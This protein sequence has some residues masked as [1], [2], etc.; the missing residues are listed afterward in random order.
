MTSCVPQGAEH[1]YRVHLLA[2]YLQGPCLHDPQ[3]HRTSTIYEIVTDTSGVARRE[4]RLQHRSEYFFS[5][6]GSWQSA[7]YLSFFSPSFPFHGNINA[8]RHVDLFKWQPSV[9]CGSIMMAAGLLS[10][11]K[12]HKMAISGGEQGCLCPAHRTAVLLRNHSK[13]VGKQSPPTL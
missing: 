11:Y 10:S 3:G 8:K 1:L 2:I 4:R 13:Q 5:R 6:A 7:F 9:K 12:S